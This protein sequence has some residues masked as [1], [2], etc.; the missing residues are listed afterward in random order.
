MENLNKQIY[1]NELPSKIYP[2]TISNF[3]KRVLSN[4]QGTV[5]SYLMQPILLEN[6][7]KILVGTVRP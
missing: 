1:I 6:K 3:Y 4:L 2:F 5:H 7:K